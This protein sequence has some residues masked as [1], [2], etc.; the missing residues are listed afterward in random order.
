MALGLGLG[1]GD[2]MDR[3]ADD[4]QDAIP[5]SFDSPD[6]DAV[7]AGA[8]GNYSFTS[9]PI[10]IYTTVE[11]DKKAVGHSLTPVISRDLAFAVRG[12]RF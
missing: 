3:I 6:F 7:F 12:G 9:E 4:M 11:L 10:Y 8:S 5:T 1:F 2:E